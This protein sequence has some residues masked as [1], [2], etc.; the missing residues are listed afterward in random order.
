[1][2]AS[3]MR[4]FFAIRLTSCAHPAAGWLKPPAITPFAYDKEAGEA[5]CQRQHTDSAKNSPTT[6][7][8]AT[9]PREKRRPDA[10]EANAKNN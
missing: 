2:K 1:M 3:P 4:T 8:C 10:D 9:L 7:A 5:C 6:A